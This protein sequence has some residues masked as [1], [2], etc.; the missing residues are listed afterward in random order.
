MNMVRR[1][2]FARGLPLKLW[3]DAAEYAA[4][5][6]N[7]SPTKANDGGVSPI[8]LLTMKKPNL[9]D[10]IAFGST[11]T[12]HLYTNNKSLGARGKAAIIIRKTDE[13][14]RYRFYLPR[15]RVIVLTQHVNNLVTQNTI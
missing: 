9:S 10:I 4:Y 1:M 8:E 3:C 7:R 11:C 13:M 15:E 2:V 12:A 6:L 14:K 5:I